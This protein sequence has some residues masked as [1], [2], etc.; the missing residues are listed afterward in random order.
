MT[1]DA[2]ASSISDTVDCTVDVPSTP[3]DMACSALDST[4]SLSW[5]LPTDGTTVEVSRDGLV[6]ATLG[7]S[8]TSYDDV[9]AGVGTHEYCV[10]NQIGT[11]TSAATCCS[12]RVISAPT[13]FGCVSA[14]G[15]VELNWTNTDDYDTLTL[16]RDGALLATLPGTTESYTDPS[17][18]HG[19]H[20]Y[21]LTASL[22]DQSTSATASCT[23]EVPS[24]PQNM[25]CSLSG[26]SEVQISWD[27]PASGDFI[28]L[29]RNGSPIG[30]LAGSATGATDSPGPG[31]YQ[32]CLIVNIGNGTG[33]TVCCDIVVPQ[34]MSGIACSTIGD[35]NTLSWSNGEAYDLIQISRDG[36]VVGLV[37]GTEESF[38]DFPLGAGTYSYEIIATLAGSQTA[39]INCSVTVLP[40]PINLACTFFG[41][42]V[43]LDWENTAAYTTIHIE[44]NGVLISSIPGA[45]TSSI[46]VVPAEGTYTYRIWAEHADGITTSTTCSGN[47]KAF[48]RGDANSDTNCDIAD[49]IWVL[50]WLFIGGQEP[51]CF[52]SADFDDNGIVT[53]GDAMLMIFYY[54]HADGTPLLPPA[55][56]F[57][58]A[59]LDPS[60]DMLDCIDSPY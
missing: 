28:S 60:D 37:D 21:E 32:Y 27:L 49:G 30:S 14:S 25:A 12:A 16:T 2:G 39:P 8:A 55:S 48:L 24:T 11:G 56:P 20:S 22:G 40:A 42:P 33:A 9:G 36:M 13:G 26:G 19:S 45:A 3:T 44:R 38:T 18:P 41:A 52:D 31:T 53:I 23:E 46:N 10:V 57:P 15:D 54:L 4:V 59:G 35:G 34:P 7:G 6:I 1:A 5:T 29:L 43:H 50:N 58:E 17:Q 47:V 51:T